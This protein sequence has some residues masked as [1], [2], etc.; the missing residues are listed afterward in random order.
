MNYYMSGIKLSCPIYYS[1][2]SHVA[3]VCLLNNFEVLFVFVLIWSD[4]WV[5]KWYFLEEL[6]KIY[7]LEIWIYLVR[8]LTQDLCLST[9]LFIR[10]VC[11]KIVYQNWSI[12][13]WLIAGHVFC[14]R[15]ISYAICLCGDQ[16]LHTPSC[17]WMPRT[18]PPWSSTQGISAR[19]SPCSPFQWPRHLSAWFCTMVKQTSYLISNEFHLM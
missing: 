6:I 11:L 2:Y 4:I 10:P 15:I 12:F 1:H 8:Y 17:T 18:S 5:Q 16:Q 14:A 7:Y 13:V 9:L 19:T 3:C